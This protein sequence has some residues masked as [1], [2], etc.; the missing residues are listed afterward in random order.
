MTAAIGLLVVMAIT[1][2]LSRLKPAAP[3]VDRAGVWIDSVKR[4]P[5]LRQVR[6]SGTLVPE[7]VKW[8]PAAVEGRVEQ[9][10]IRPG[11]VVKADTVVLSLSNPQLDL[12]TRDAALQLK[13]AEA[14][15]A[16]QKAKTRGAAHGPGS[17]RGQCEIV[18]YRSAI[19]G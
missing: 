1:L 9:I 19:A 18:I 6:G 10:F 3:G 8:I 14:D 7:E 4:G 16:D 5:M 11:T 12:E 15:F 2:G 13:G 17:L